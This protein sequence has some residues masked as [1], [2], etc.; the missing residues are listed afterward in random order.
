LGPKRT[1]ESQGLP[2]LPGGRQIPPVVEPPDA[3]WLLDT[4]EICLA[5]QVWNLLD[6]EHAAR[7]LQEEAIAAGF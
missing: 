3:K 4:A 6:F 1:L 2:E 7:V 5:A